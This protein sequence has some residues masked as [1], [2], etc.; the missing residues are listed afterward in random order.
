MQS[1]LLSTNID[2]AIALIRA[3]L[4]GFMVLYRFRWFYDPTQ[5]DPWFSHFRRELLKARLCS[6]NYPSSLVM[7]GTLASVE[8]LGGIMLIVG[9]LTIPAA[10]S[11]L[12]ILLFATCCTAKENTLVQKP[13]DTIDTISCYLRT[14]EPLYIT[15]ALVLVLTGP[16]KY[17]FDYFLFG[18]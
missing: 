16:G 10:V 15:M 2:L 8:V 18:R 14:I 13:V 4:G 12:L 3:L 7:C 17:S 11:L 1:L 9:F 5:T 6:C